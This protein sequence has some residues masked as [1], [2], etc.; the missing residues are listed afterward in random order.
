[1]KLKMKKYN[2]SSEDNHYYTEAYYKSYQSSGLN[3]KKY[4]HVRIVPD[5]MDSSWTYPKGVAGKTLGLLTDTGN[6]LVIKVCDKKIFLDYSEAEIVLQLL[7]IEKMNRPHH[8]NKIGSLFKEDKDWQPSKE[9]INYYT[10]KN[11]EDEYD[12]KEV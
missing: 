4:G 10:N 7:I 3:K 1:M 9:I 5:V 11:E 8:F 12:C 2:I 6:G